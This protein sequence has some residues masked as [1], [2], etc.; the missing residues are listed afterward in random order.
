MRLQLRE[1]ANA[2]AQT[3]QADA[4]SYD[5]RRS[6]NDTVCENGHGL[7]LHWPTPIFK[8]T[9]HQDIGTFHRVKNKLFNM[10]QQQDGVRFTNH[11]GWQSTHDL[12]ETDDK[13]LINVRSM[14]YEIVFDMLRSQWEAANSSPATGTFRIDIRTSWANI[15]RA[16][17]SNDP[18]VH[19]GA[20]F[21]GVIYLDDGGDSENKIGLIDPRAQAVMIPTSGIFNMGLGT[22]ISLSPKPGLAIVFP[23]WLQH[24]VNPHN[25]PNPRVAIA[26]N[27][28]VKYP[29]KDP[30][31]NEPLRF[32]VM[33]FHHLEGLAARVGNAVTYVPYKPS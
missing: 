4:L 19:P 5:Y 25:G 30:G 26:F 6:Y 20:H 9:F 28:L 3:C 2:M 10:E 1:V 15:N 18:H 21:S 16:G 14:A 29:D 32:A 12:F 11:G 17:N 27:A 22:H 13:D 24:Y 31:P 23:S 33:R 7:E 8:K